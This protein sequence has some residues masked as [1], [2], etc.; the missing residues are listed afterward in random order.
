MILFSTPVHASLTLT[1]NKTQNTLG[2]SIWNETFA[3]NES[4][5]FYVNMPKNAT[6]SNAKLNLSGIEYSNGLYSS[7]NSS[8]WSGSNLSNIH[9]NNSKLYINESLSN[10][11]VYSVNSYSVLSNNITFRVS[12][13]NVANSEYCGIKFGFNATNYPVSGFYSLICSHAISGAIIFTSRG[14]GSI[15]SGFTTSIVADVFYNYSIRIYGNNSLCFSLGSESSCVDATTYASSTSNSISIYNSNTNSNI[16]VDYVVVNDTTIVDTFNSTNYSINPYLDVANDGD[17]QWSYSGQFN[18]LN[19]QTSDFSSEINSYL[20]N[21]YPYIDGTCDVPFVLHSD[22]AGIMQIKLNATITYDSQTFETPVY[23]GQT[24]N[25]WVKVNSTSDISNVNAWLVYNGTSY[26]YT[27]KS[28]S[29]SYWIFTKSLTIPTVSADSNISFYWNF[30]YSNATGTY[31]QNFSSN[32]QTVYQLKLIN[33]T[34]GNITLNFTAYDE[35]SKALINYKMDATLTYWPSGKPFTKNFSYSYTGNNTY[36][37]CI[38]PSTATLYADADIKYW[39]D[40]YST[41]YYYL[42]NATLTNSTQNIKLYLLNSSESTLIT[43]IVKDQVENPVGNEIVLAQKQ[44][45]GTGT[46]TQVS[47]AKSDFSGY[48]YTYLKLHENYKFFLTKNGIVQREFEPMQLESSTLTFYVSQIDTPEYFSYYN[49]V[50]TSCTNISNILT[51]S[52]VDTSGLTADMNFYVGK[53]DQVGETTVCD[54]TS[55]GSSGTFVCDLSSGGNFRYILKGTYHSNPITYVWQ[56][57]YIGGAS[58]VDFGVV[59]LVLTL[60]IVM[61]VAYMTHNDVKLCLVSTAFAIIFCSIISLIRFGA[62]AM[63]MTFTVAIISGIIAFKI[64]F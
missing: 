10:A 33:C 55:S 49:N 9:I 40:S 37:V 17:A 41:R 61:F 29:S 39:N 8:V 13:S 28:Q 54:N 53:I 36:F 52:W 24:S 15:N 38:A 5:T 32:N 59:G 30:T 44:E 64:R 46:Y 31:A 14:S 18:Q 62:D 22:S 2:N 51:C 1:Y 25:F 50:A 35:N 43:M 60:L 6:V 47:E 21:C 58:V 3:G 20:K 42:Q 63:A 27:T 12:F 4:H 57:G 48:A 56:S 16:I 34:S 7:V 19:N 23:E 11:Y 26:A 45:I